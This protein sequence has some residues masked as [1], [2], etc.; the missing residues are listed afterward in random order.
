MTYDLSNPLHRQQFKARV[1]KMYKDQRKVEL[2]DKS[3]RTLHQNSYFHVL[4]RILAAE[5]GV[6]ENYAK[7]EYFKRQA[8][9]DTFLKTVVDP[10]TN[11]TNDVLGES[12]ELTIDQMAI[13]IDKFRRWSEEQGIYLPEA[14]LKGEGDEMEFKDEDE[15]HAFE[16]AVI[17]TGRLEKYL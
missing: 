10:L 5:T 11:Q 3:I 4:C 2:T 16:Q 14:H 17:E 9:P 1:Q 12:S 8:N 6:T 15:Q 13:C 7:E